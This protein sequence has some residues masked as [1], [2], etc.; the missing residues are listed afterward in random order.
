MHTLRTP[1]VSFIKLRTII[2][3]SDPYDNIV[4]CTD[5]IACS[6]TPARKGYT[7]HQRQL[8]AGGITLYAKNLHSIQY[9]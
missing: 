2:W 1:E 7:A 8:P 5:M 4:Q 3:I 9:V 6:S